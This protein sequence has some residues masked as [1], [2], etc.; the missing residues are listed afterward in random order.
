MLSI[1]NVS[2]IMINNAFQVSLS[3]TKLLLMGSKCFPCLAITWVIEIVLGCLVAGYRVLKLLRF[4]LLN[5][6]IF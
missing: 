3:S 6:G 4:N 5:L 1:Q 2:D